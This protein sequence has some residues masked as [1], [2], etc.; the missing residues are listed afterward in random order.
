MTVGGYYETT[1]TQEQIFHAEWKLANRL[2]L[3]T[4]DRRHFA[5]AV[6]VTCSVNH[7]KNNRDWR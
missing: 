7:I 2:C 6:V 1:E 3:P 5:A 4:K